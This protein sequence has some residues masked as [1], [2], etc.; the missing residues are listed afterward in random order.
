MQSDVPAQDRGASLPRGFLLYNPVA[1]TPAH[2]FSGGLL[3]LAYRLLLIQC[4]SDMAIDLG[5]MND[6]IDDLDV[7]H[8][9]NWKQT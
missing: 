5:R 4:S 6:G 8:T 9:G 1:S 2:L 7:D 3:M